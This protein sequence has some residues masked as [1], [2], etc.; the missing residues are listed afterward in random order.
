MEDSKDV[1]NDAYK[2]LSPFSQAILNILSDSDGTGWFEERVH[3]AAGGV[4]IHHFSQSTGMHWLHELNKYKPLFGT[5]PVWV[6]ELHP[7]KRLRLCQLG[8]KY[9]VKLPPSRDLEDW[10]I[11]GKTLTEPKVAGDGRRKRKRVSK[12]NPIY[13]EVRRA[14]AKA[15]EIEAA[16]AKFELSGRGHEARVTLDRKL[17]SILRNNNLPSVYISGYGANHHYPSRIF[18]RASKSLKKKWGQSPIV[19]RDSYVY[20]KGVSEE[21]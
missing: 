8:L 14:L 5:P 11:L 10:E 1:L 17:A 15:T 19:C 2:G 12:A 9:G 13:E 7:Y 18:E 16:R 21:E 6:L 3:L 20:W 4:V